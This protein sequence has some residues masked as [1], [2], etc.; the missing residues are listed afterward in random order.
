MTTPFPS[1]FAEP[2][3]HRRQRKQRGLDRLLLRLSAAKT[4]LAKH[5]SAQREE[6]MKGGNQYKEPWHRR[7][8]ICCSTR[9]CKGW[10]YVDRWSTG[11]A[12]HSCNATLPSPRRWPGR[13]RGAAKEQAENAAGGDASGND[14][15]EASL[16]QAVKTI[17]DKLA[18]MNMQGGGL[19]EQFKQVAV[20]LAA[21]EAK[22]AAQPKADR[23]AAA[24]KKL[25]SVTKQF[26]QAFQEK[27]RADEKAAK[28]RDRMERKAK[29]VLEAE[30][31]IKEIQSTFVAEE[32]DE[33][34]GV[35]EMLLTGD[36]ETLAQGEIDKALKI[37]EA[38]DEEAVKRVAEVK[39]EVV[40]QLKANAQ[41]FA[42]QLQE[43]LIAARER[44][45]SERRTIL[46]AQKKRKVGDDK[47]EESQAGGG[48]QE[49]PDDKNNATQPA[50]ASTTSPESSD[51]YLEQLRSQEKEAAN[52]AGSIGG[53]RK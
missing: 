41:T 44:A 39:K 12:C 42:A 36:V 9:G 4:R 53:A 37:D 22:P 2:A 45:V 10:V 35:I 43:H 16:M 1:R 46:Q 40:H 28:A 21:E 34:P 33:A 51:D 6:K 23:L 15:Q 18:T 14:G 27:Q 8:Y 20:Q 11:L 13:G 24:A 30:K 49:K 7:Q 52:A 5:H 25:G 29:E 3:W 50:T 48:S 38:L 26:N 47:A 19:G 17:T 31:E 32:K